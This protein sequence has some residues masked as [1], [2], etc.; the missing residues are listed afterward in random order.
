MENGK[1]TALHIKLT[2]HHPAIIVTAASSKEC[3]GIELGPDE[4]VS[5]SFR[6]DEYKAGN[7]VKGNPGSGI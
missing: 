5:Q 6:W 1:H 2:L 7:K 3:G 4:Q